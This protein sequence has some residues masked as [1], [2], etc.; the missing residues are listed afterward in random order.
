MVNAFLSTEAQLKSP[1]LSVQDKLDAVQRCLL[2]FR[3][4]A[5]LPLSDIN[6]STILHRICRLASLLGDLKSKSMAENGAVEDGTT[7]ITFPDLGNDPLMSSLLEEVL[8]RARNRESDPGMVTSD[9][10]VDESTASMVLYTLSS[11]NLAISSE[12]LDVIARALLAAREEWSAKRIV[13]VLLSLGRL[14]VSPL[15]GQLH[16]ALHNATAQCLEE[17]TANEMSTLLWGMAHS[18]H[19]PGNDFLTAAMASLSLKDQDVPDFRRAHMVGVANILDA[20]AYM[21]WVPPAPSAA[22][23]ALE[24]VL[25]K[26]WKQMVNG[27]NGDDDFSSSSSY[28]RGDGSRYQR[29]DSNSGGGNLH[30]QDRVRSQHHRRNQQREYLDDDAEGGVRVRDL[31]ELQNIARSWERERRRG[32]AAFLQRQQQ[33]QLGG[34]G[35]EVSSS[36]SSSSS[37]IYNNDSS[38]SSG[39]VMG[40]LNLEALAKRAVMARAA[41]SSAA[42]LEQT[43]AS[44]IRTLRATAAAASR[45]SSNSNSNENEEDSVYSEK[46]QLEARRARFEGDAEKLAIRFLTGEWPSSSSDA[47][48]PSSLGGLPGSDSGND[49]LEGSSVSS[50][51]GEHNHLVDASTTT[52]TTTDTRQGKGRKRILRLGTLLAESSI[53]PASGRTVIQPH[54]EKSHLWATPACSN[55]DDGVDDDD[56]LFHSRDSSPVE[57]VEDLSFSSTTTTTIESS[58]LLEQPLE[59]NL[60]SSS[61]S[62]LQDDDFPITS[63]VEKEF[64][65][66]AFD[67]EEF[68]DEDEEEE[69]EESDFFLLHNATTHVEDAAAAS[70]TRLVARAVEHFPT[71]RLDQAMHIARYLSSL[72]HLDHT[73]L[74]ALRDKM[75]QSLDSHHQQQQESQV[76]PKTRF[77]PFN[78]LSVADFLWIF[79]VL[80]VDNILTPD[81]I[82]RVMNAALEDPFFSPLALSRCAWSMAVLN[83]LDVSMF[84][85][86]CEK[87]ASALDK[88]LRDRQE[89]EEAVDDV[90]KNNN[91]P[92]SVE[93]RQKRQND[94]RRTSSKASTSVQDGN[95]IILLKQLYQAALH[96]EIST[97][98]SHDTLLPP[99]LYDRST[100][101]WRDRRNF[102]STSSLQ[103]QVAAALR[104]KG[105][106]CE[107]EFCPSDSNIVIDVAVFDDET[108]SRVAVEVDGP[109]HFSTNVPGHAL[110]AVKLRNELLRH[111][112]WQV[113]TVPYFEWTRLRH[114][115]R[116][117]YVKKKV[118]SKLA[119]Q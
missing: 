39:G 109:S 118:L 6:I 26:Q 93:I 27:D 42:N 10:G 30:E 89:A 21:D 24:E 3:R 55:D 58:P 76:S 13:M 48:F 7:S 67:E 20:V 102:L 96:L 78:T 59:N 19:S 79:A 23:K 52:T 5:A 18:Y 71:I 38:S 43:A 54:Y 95:E 114:W 68:D 22:K 28:S 4:I 37:S 65:E 1:H 57:D 108:N 113:V 50:S 35:G 72:R 115:E 77:Y 88:E 105:L 11:L 34:D 31:R 40:E 91:S 73:L 80:G 116:G 64:D 101:A 117:T 32:L 84:R 69:D 83:Q 47:G 45:Q 97:G 2:S 86:I 17:F 87:I 82:T 98:E 75:E 70:L 49:V 112:G 36:S 74:I 46:Q 15:K 92:H 110:G 104:N 62:S 33:Q 90:L 107:L 53:Q 25:D 111:S 29:D 14:G 8:Q 106:H 81:L 63:E 9:Q 61:S 56:E 41:K 85:R 99:I 94:W 100:A 12:D 103:R 16:T 44:I 66:E 60:S 51:S 119:R